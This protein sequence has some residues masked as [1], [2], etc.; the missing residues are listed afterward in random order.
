M[1]LPCASRASISAESCRPSSAS[2]TGPESRSKTDVPVTNSSSEG[3]R[4]ESSSSRT[5]P[6]TRRSSPANSWA[7]VGKP[8]CSRI[9][10]AARWR[11]AG[12]PSVRRWRVRASSGES[13]SP[14][15][16]SCAAASDRVMASSP[17]RSSAKL[18]WARS[19]A[20]GRTAS[21]RE[22]SASCRP[23]PDA[24]ADRRHH[25]ARL[26]SVEHMQVVEYEHRG[27]LVAGQAPG[28]AAQRRRRPVAAARG[29]CLEHLPADRLDLSS[30]NATDE[31]SSRGS[32][33][34]GSSVTHAN[35]RPSQAAH[36]RS[37]VVLPYPAG[38][39]S[40]TTG[41]CRASTS[42]RTRRGRGTSPG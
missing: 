7:R 32:L 17:A 23:C 15:R 13:S 3:A 42:R 37:T 9:D 31:S 18:P 30:A 21:L 27:Q 11:P 41:T 26:L 38:A 8:S 20:T 6:V 10:R 34:P 35:G 24:C 25:V 36:S 40:R 2:H 16:L 4:V 1:T 12:Q 5:Y 19:L 39:T 22:A 28:Q 29:K 33:S 14:A